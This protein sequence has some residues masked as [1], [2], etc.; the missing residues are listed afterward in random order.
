M[1]MVGTAGQ[2]C[3]HRACI[4]KIRRFPEQLAFEIDHGIAAEHKGPWPH[5]CHG[6]RFFTREAPDLFER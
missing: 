5:K 4:F 2:T 3:Q 6:S 1:N